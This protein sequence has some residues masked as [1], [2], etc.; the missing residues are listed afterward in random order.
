MG[1]TDPRKMGLKGIR[2]TR[3]NE[4]GGKCWCCG[5]WLS[6]RGSGPDK[7]AAFALD[8]FAPVETISDYENTV[9]ACHRCT[10]LRSDLAD[11]DIVMTGAEFRAELSECGVDSL[12][13]VLRRAQQEKEASALSA[14]DL[15]DLVDTGS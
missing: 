13:A 12:F 14:H 15:N 4:Q 1:E 7:I 8:L 5:C 9:A 11:A 10:S 6:S 2:N 3:A